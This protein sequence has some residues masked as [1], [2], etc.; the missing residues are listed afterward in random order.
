MSA[1]SSLAGD[2]YSAD[3]EDEDAEP[4]EDAVA[5]AMFRRFRTAMN[6][7]DDAAGVEAFKKLLAC[8]DGDE[9]DEEPMG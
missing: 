1:L 7:T 6:G 9:G 2:G 4:D 8:C 3:E 5:K